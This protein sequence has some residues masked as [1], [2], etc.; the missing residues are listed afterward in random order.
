MNKLAERKNKIIL[1]K[2]DICLELYRILQAI[3]KYFVLKMA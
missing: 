1:S 2:N 3:F